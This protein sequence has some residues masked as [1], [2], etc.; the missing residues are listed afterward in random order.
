MHRVQL[1][2][3]IERRGVADRAALSGED[4]LAVAGVLVKWV[5]VGRRFERLD[6]ERQRVK[7]LVA[8]ASALLAAEWRGPRGGLKVAVICERIEPLVDDGVRF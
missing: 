5:G 4:L 8:I 1:V 6:I 3:G 2:V 7:L